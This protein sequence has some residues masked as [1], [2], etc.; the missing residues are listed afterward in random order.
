MGYSPWGHTELDTI[1]RL[2]LSLFSHFCLITPIIAFHTSEEL[3]INL[4][5]LNTEYKLLF[6]SFVKWASSGPNHS[7]TVGKELE[8]ERSI[9][10]LNKNCIQQMKD[11][12]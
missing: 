2:T 1:E 3:E 7:R 11:A 5:K 9:Q 4:K 8:K 10:S 6:L 12:S